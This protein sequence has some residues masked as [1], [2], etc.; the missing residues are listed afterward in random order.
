MLVGFQIYPNAKV[1]IGT[2]SETKWNKFQ[3]IMAQKQADA[4]GRQVGG[5]KAKKAHVGGGGGA[6]RANVGVAGEAAELES[7]NLWVAHPGAAE[8]FREPK[9]MEAALLLRASGARGK[10]A[11]GAAGKAPAKMCEA[12]SRG[13]DRICPAMILAF[14]T[15]TSCSRGAFGLTT[16]P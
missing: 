2:G 13:S 3:R 5:G 14:L 16:L 7:T 9:V 11:G 15:G 6:A 4:G 1:N 12:L 8:L 10:A